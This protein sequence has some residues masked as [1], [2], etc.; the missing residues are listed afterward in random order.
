MLH[1]QKYLAEC[2]VGSRRECEALIAQGRVTVNGEPVRPGAEVDPGV[3][4]IALDG[5]AVEPASKVYI[6]LNKPRG[7]V[8][9]VKDDDGRRTVADLVAHRSRL[10][11]VGRLDMDV[12]GAI[13][14]TNDGELAHRLSSREY[15]VERIYIASVQ[16]E[17]SEAKI[18]R[19]REGV[20]M[21]DGVTV[22]ARATVLHT[23]LNTT[24]ARLTFWEGPKKSLRRLCAAVGHPVLE[25]RSV[26]IG[27]AHIGRLQPG[28]WRELTG[29]E[30]ESLRRCVG[31]GAEDSA[32]VAAFAG[33]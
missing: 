10:F 2:G 22:R 6:L 25:L 27:P 33:R 8:S 7:V 24:L 26:A 28:E 15:A 18:L 4:R 19:M 16:G 21:A 1:L 13:L 31:L 23:G 9:S 11:P 14:L 30:A 20:L 12:E 3:D 5:R 29:T 32:A 17:M